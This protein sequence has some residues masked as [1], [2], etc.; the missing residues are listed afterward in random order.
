MLVAK[1][2]NGHWACRAHH[3]R[4]SYEIALRLM[5]EIRDLPEVEDFTVEH[6]YRDYNVNADATA[7]ETLDLFQSHLHANG[8]VILESWRQSDFHRR[9]AE[10]ARAQ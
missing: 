8:I 10:I 7:N 1:Q 4:D 6:I 5:R 9:L 2:I 3:L